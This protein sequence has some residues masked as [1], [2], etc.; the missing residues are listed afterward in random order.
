[1]HLYKGREI[2]R[3]DQKSFCKKDDLV[4]VKSTIRV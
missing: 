1:M 3:E 4:L 2:L